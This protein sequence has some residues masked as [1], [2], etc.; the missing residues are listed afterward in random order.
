MA[1]QNP[2]FEDAGAL[3]G[4][5]EH[6]TLTA[7]TSLEVLA[8][9][10]TAPED[11]W[12]DFE[13]W[14][15]LLDSLEDVVVVLAFFDSAYLLGLS[16]DDP[17]RIV[18]GK[19]AVTVGLPTADGPGVLLKSSASFTQATWLHLRLDVIVNTNGDVVLKVF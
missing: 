17:H 19:G 12:E 10:G 18:L 3:P 14:Y 11:G 8:G 9:F 1:L 5:A 15:A 2:S 16:D 7:V 6:W 4:E 13:R